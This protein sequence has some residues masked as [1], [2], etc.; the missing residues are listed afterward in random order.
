MSGPPSLLRPALLAL[1][2]SAGVA[3]AGLRYMG[4]APAA[5]STM[6]TFSDFAVE[7]GE[8]QV[9]LSDFKGQVVVV[10]FGYARCPDI[11]PTTLATVASAFDALEPAQLARVRGLFVSV[12][13]ERDLP[14]QARAYA[15]FFHP[16]IVGGTSDATAVAAIAED[17]GIRFAP[18]EGASEAMGYT[19]DH[20]SIVYLVA[21]DGRMKTA[22]PHGGDPTALAAAIVKVLTTAADGLQ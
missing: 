19:V 20:T 21:P 12:D 1:A 22:I 10:Y 15:E 6:P 14:G 4:G 18:A 16:Q 13:P 3:W 8:A 11:C 2:V 9:R 7:S 5:D 17:W